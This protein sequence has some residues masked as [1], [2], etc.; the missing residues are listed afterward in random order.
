MLAPTIE[1]IRQATGD[2]RFDVW[3]LFNWVTVSYYWVFLYD[4]GL[5]APTYYEYTASSLPNFTAPIYYT[6]KNNIFVNDALFDIFSGYLFSTVV[7]FL[8]KIEPN[9]VV[10]TFLPLSET[11]ALQPIDQQIL[12]SYSCVERRIKG[13]VSATVAVLVADYA[14]LSGAYYLILF[15]CGWYLRGR[16]QG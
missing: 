10:P 6:S 15:I 3:R 5:L 1:L 4:F 2:P 12:R 8:K 11:N 14:F 16:A 7:P 13:W 9:L